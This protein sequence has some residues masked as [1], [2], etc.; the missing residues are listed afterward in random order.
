MKRFSA[1]LVAACL[2]AAALSLAEEADSHF[3]RVYKLI[4]DGDTS[5]SNS[6]TRAAAKSYREAQT[7][8]KSLQKAHPAWNE[9]VVKF[10]LNY[11]AEK[12]SELGESLTPE[13]TPAVNPSAP[14]SATTQVAE[15]PKLR[16]E[17]NGLNQQLRAL[18]SD[19]RLLE[20]KLREALIAQPAAV[21]PQEL[22]K[23]EDRIV[24]LQK[25]N[26][27]LKVGLEKQK[28]KTVPAVDPNALEQMKRALGE[29]NLKLQEQTAANAKLEAEKKQLAARLQDRSSAAPSAVV[30]TAPRELPTTNARLQAQLERIN[31]LTREKELLQRQLTSAGPAGQLAALKSEN[32]VLKKQLASVRTGAKPRAR[33]ESL[34]QDLQTTRT[35]LAAQKSANEALRLEKLVL[36]RQLKESTSGATFAARVQNRPANSRASADERKVERAENERLQRLERERDD[37]KKKLDA[38]NAQLARRAATS[39]TAMNPKS[40]REVAALNARI[41]AL[42]TKRVPYTAEELALFKAPAAAAPRVSQVASN[43]KSTATFQLAAENSATKSVAPAVAAE[44]IRETKPARKS[45]EDLPPGAG[46]LVTEAQ[47]AFAA[48]RFEEAETKYKQALKLDEKSVFLLA[49]LATIQLEQNR[50]EEAEK[51]LNL[52]LANAPDDAFSLSLFGILKFR[53]EKYDDALTSLSQAVKLDPQN[54]ETQN[55][56]GITLS[57]KG[58]RDAAEGAL[59]KAIQLSPGYPSAHYNLAVVYATQQPPF[60]EMARLH[61]QKATA[62]GHPKNADLE[63]ILAENSSAETK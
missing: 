46:P 1:L 52:A 9:K 40:S 26:E 4:Q 27:L 8:L 20:A 5:A 45:I 28:S 56:L 10:R 41:A 39:R 24:R 31:T 14:V 33:D 23:A 53:Q 25:E 21:D 7:E 18:E 42:E 62:A 51:N 13:K 11:L 22:R 47:R 60:R 57:Q 50:F 59:R 58:Q 55:Y 34:R 49:N 16:Q 43:T 35:E 37:L 32:E 48:R 63:K 36:E 38:A 3:I 30:K 12:L 17:L 44:P 2:G 15:D 54:A 29:A 19:K 6:Q 61:Y